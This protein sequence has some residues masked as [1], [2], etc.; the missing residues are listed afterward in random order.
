MENRVNRRIGDYEVLRRLG[1]GGMGEVLQVRHTL[2]GRI[3]AMKVLLPN[4]VGNRQRQERFLREIQTVAKL[5]HPNI[6]RLCTAATFE[7][8]IVMV[9][10]YVDGVTVESMV[11]GKPL[12]VGKAVRYMAQ[13]L[14][15]LAYA[16]RQGI[17]H[18]DFKP[19]N[20]MVTA[21]GTVKL[22]DFGIALTEGARLTQNGSTIGTFY[23]MSPEQV[24]GEEVDERSDIYAAGVTLYEMVTGRTPFT[25]TTPDTLMNKHVNEAPK[26]P[27]DLRE[28]L[29]PALNQVILKMLAKAPGD[30][31]QTADEAQEALEA[32][33]PGR[34]LTQD[35]QS[36]VH[37]TT[38]TETPAW[39]GAAVA[40]PTGRPV[41]I[42]GVA[43]QFD[44]SI[45]KVEPV[46]PPAPPRSRM[47]IQIGVTAV[48]L[49]GAGIGVYALIHHDGSGS[50][51]TV[52][53]P[54]VEPKP[55]QPKPVQPELGDRS[56]QTVPGGGMTVARSELPGS[57]SDP[58]RA[59][60]EQAKLMALNGPRGTKGKQ[61]LLYGP[62][63]AS[64]TS[65]G[66]GSST[67]VERR[68]PI[69]V[70]PTVPTITPEQ[71][72]RLDRIEI[73]LD[74]VESRS[75]A[76][77]SAINSRRSQM[78][79]Q[80]L[81]LRG[82]IVGEQLSMNNSRVKAREAFN[83]NDVDRTNLYLTQEKSD[84]QKLETFLGR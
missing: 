3:E 28:D 13:A 14:R 29:P 56:R 51:Q 74:S 9:M 15:A 76:T 16:H 48:V 11:D 34:V 70:R 50:K 53:G 26:P 37:R 27:S 64:G 54:V 72:A 78:A 22:M 44:P 43:G 59:K 63:L 46:Q 79:A 49:A 23:F 77:D 65:I 52:V 35:E 69:P 6:A 2:T 73:E 81:Q 25:G 66:S 68:D 45:R 40:D 55:V 61:G 36:A 10:D 57:Q 21:D 60:A 1:L 80:G 7:D 17:V 24:R 75:L 38:V 19:A 58:T 12:P 82:D 67:P 41:T 8:Q 84:L 47:W 4:Y 32:A 30:R 62:G 31:Y 18:R 5:E 20:L 83:A 39:K 33:M 71:K 42:D